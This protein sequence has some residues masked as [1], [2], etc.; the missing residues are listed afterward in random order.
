[1]IEGNQQRRITTSASDK[2]EHQMGIQKGPNGISKG[3]SS[4]E[5]W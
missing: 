3:T 5:P 4:R 2:R 1:M